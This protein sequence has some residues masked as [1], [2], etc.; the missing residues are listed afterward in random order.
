MMLPPSYWQWS[1]NWLISHLKIQ[2][3]PN[4][5][6]T[7]N[8]VLL[9]RGYTEH[10]MRRKQTEKKWKHEKCMSVGTKTG[11]GLLPK[12][13][14][15][16]SQ[17]DFPLQ[18]CVNE[19]K[20]GDASQGLHCDT[21]PHFNSFIEGNLQELGPDS[22]LPASVWD[23]K[24]C[25]GYIGKTVAHLPPSACYMKGCQIML[26]D[27][28]LT[29]MPLHQNFACSWC[30][31]HLMFFLF[32]STISWNVLKIKTS[33]RCSPRSAISKIYCWSQ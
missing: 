17:M 6:V 11:H 33:E 2:Y 28:H 16:Y 15:E 5:S 7:L 22:Y 14:S 23:G 3:E 25:L 9:D 30:Q 27:I 29:Q 8:G 26:S 32:S 19:R 21:V 4:I 10:C 1:T 24:A 31:L 18:S 20:Q 12:T 13:N